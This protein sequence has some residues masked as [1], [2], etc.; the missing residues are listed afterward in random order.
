MALLQRRHN[1]IIEPHRNASLREISIEG[2]YA[3]RLECF[4]RTA[5]TFNRVHVMIHRSA[6]HASRCM[7]TYRAS[8]NTEMN[9]IR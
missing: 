8:N 9:C 3:E 5:F 4:F 6:R 2:R 1:T 7:I